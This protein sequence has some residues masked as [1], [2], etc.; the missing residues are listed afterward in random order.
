MSIRGFSLNRI[1]LPV[2][3]V[4][5]AIVGAISACLNFI[6]KR[7]DGSGAAARLIEADRATK[8]RVNESY[9]KLPLAFEINRGQA[10]D[11][12]KFLA[13]GGNYDFLLA[14]AEATLHLRDGAGNLT[15]QPAIV[16]MKFVGGSPSP[17]LEGLDELPGKSNYLIGAD[18]KQWR[19]NIPNY[20]RVRYDEL[21]PGV[22]AVFY[23]NQQRLEY[24]FVVAPGANPRAIKLSFDGAKKI[25][26]D[27][28]GD[29]ILHL[30]RSELRQRKPV[31]YQEVNGEKRMVAGRYVVKGDQVGF[32]IGRYDRS[33]ELVIDPVLNYLARLTA[34]RS[35]AVDSQGNA[36][37]TASSGADP[38]PKDI[39]VTKLNAT[40]TQQVFTTMIGGLSFD[41]PMDLAVDAAGSAYVTGVTDSTDFPGNYPGLAPGASAGVCFK[42]ADGAVNWSN[43]GK[44][45]PARSMIAL[46]IDPN[47][48]MTLYAEVGAFS[49]ESALYKS[50]DGGKNWAVVSLGNVTRARP[51]AVA[52]GNS[53]II[54]VGTSSGLRKSVDGGATWSESGLNVADVSAFVIDPKNPLNCHAGTPVGLYKS[55]DGGSNW[56]A[57]DTGLPSPFRA[58]Q[59]AGNP[60]TTSTI[61]ALG[62]NSTNIARLY[63]TTDSAATWEDV[64]P[65]K[66]PAAVAVDPTNS[67]VVY[68]GTDRGMLKSIDGGKNWQPAGLD[69]HAVLFVAVDPV[70]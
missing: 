2:S 40:G 42:S 7:V 8:N 53:N 31:V 34:G 5:L 12:I 9:G 4:A 59:L 52:P 11:Q 13:R 25:G 48:P 24:D 30:E 1:E 18:S 55:I 46:V 23:G 6:P 66:G 38:G 33:R 3:I 50:S 57:A 14:P 17:W 58:R 67:S 28:N 43:S 56:S 27:A 64:T 47:N 16:R 36:Y 41:D 29:L 10:S 51:L 49:M 69:D 21:W 22:D 39:L 61:Y 63:K 15:N 26:V 37:I 65:D 60:V 62:L 45:L 68:A 35:I 44:G 70:N 19:T 20:A 32:E 54:F